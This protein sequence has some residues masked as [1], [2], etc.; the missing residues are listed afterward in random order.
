MNDAVLYPINNICALSF[1]PVST[2]E[3]GGCTGHDGTIRSI[4]LPTPEPVGSCAPSEVGIAGEVAP[5]G[6]VTVCCAG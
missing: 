2:V 4:N 5:T 3:P 1:D 6:T